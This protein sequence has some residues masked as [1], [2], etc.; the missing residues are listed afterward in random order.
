MNIK[1]GEIAQEIIAHP[2]DATPPTRED[3]YMRAHGFGGAVINLL[4]MPDQDDIHEFL[5]W[6]K[7][8]NSIAHEHPLAFT[9]LLHEFHTNMWEQFLTEALL[10]IE[11]SKDRDDMIDFCFHYLLKLP[12]EKRAYYRF[13]LHQQLDIWKSV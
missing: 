8:N 13:R 11:Q 10:I 2:D 12:L 5:L 4:D 9:V 1:E 6:R 3:F 7:K